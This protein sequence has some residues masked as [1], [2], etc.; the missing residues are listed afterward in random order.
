MGGATGN[1]G[2]VAF[3][4]VVHSTSFC[5]VCSHFAA[6][7]NEVRDRNEDFSSALRKIKFPQGREIESHDVI[8]WFGD[9]NYRINLSGDEVKKAAS[10]SEFSKLWPYDQLLQ[11]KGNGLVFVGFQEGALSFAPTYKYD[12]FSD[13]YDTSEKCRVPAWTDRILWKERRIPTDTKLIRFEYS[14][15]V[16]QW[17]L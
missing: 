12:T 7:Q 3:R 10:S 8:F 4:M 11:Q 14:S 2:S 6:G 13:D 15:I 5:F 16:L 9:F 1:K 17:T